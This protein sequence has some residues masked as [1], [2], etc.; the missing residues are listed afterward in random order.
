[1]NKKI[2]PIMEP[3]TFEQVKTYWAFKKIDLERIINAL[4]N[5]PKTGMNEWDEPIR[6]AKNERI[7]QLRLIE[8]LINKHKMGEF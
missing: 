1:M 3:R 4:S 8:S 2:I 6:Q 5:A 7:L